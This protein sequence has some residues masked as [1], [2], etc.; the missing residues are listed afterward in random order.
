MRLEGLL[1]NGVPDHGPV[2]D[3]AFGGDL[4]RHVPPPPDP[5][6][7]VFPAPVRL[8]D[9][10]AADDLVGQYRAGFDEHA[11]VHAQRAGQFAQESADVDRRARIVGDQ[12]LDYQ[13]QAQ[14]AGALADLHENWQQHAQEAEQ[15]AQQ[16]QDEAQEAQEAAGN[17]QE[18]EEFYQQQARNAEQKAAEAE[19]RVE[20]LQRQVREAEDHEEDWQ[21]QAQWAEE[22]EQEDALEQQR[23]V[24]ESEQQLDYYQKQVR[25]AQQEARE[26][27]K[28]VRDARTE[29]QDYQQWAQEAHENARVAQQ[30]AQN[31]E[32]RARVAGQR[33]RELREQSPEDHR[34]DA[35]HF[36]KRAQR[37]GGDQALQLDS[38]QPPR[39]GG[40]AGEATTHAHD[41]WSV[42]RQ[43][44]LGRD[45]ELRREHAYRLLG[46]HFAVPP[47][48]PIGGGDADEG[49]LV[50]DHRAIDAGV[51][52]MQQVAARA[53]ANLDAAR[54]ARLRLQ[55]GGA[56][57]AADATQS[58]LL[59][60]ERVSRRLVVAV[61]ATLRDLGAVNHDMA[62]LDQQIA[63]EFY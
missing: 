59:M 44:R 34:R 6:M 14:Q 29:A 57:Q 45:E 24:R 4:P 28:H 15:Q 37:L 9:L 33:A 39:L 3:E 8:D 21:Q 12:A 49:R 17:V 25:E 30:Q 16:A 35:Q 56:G 63:A 60:I 48:P 41:L 46:G 42:G 19:Q 7:P 10:S 26:A 36:R 22:E 5:D 31:A 51:R 18:D 2:A 52:E 1:P 54:Q 43:A 40:M 53:Q 47:P 38:D 61:K 13:R 50:Y 27:Q 32:Q 55:D 62:A 11:G 23:L 58:K 20:V